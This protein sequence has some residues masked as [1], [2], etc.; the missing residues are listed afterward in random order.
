MNVCKCIDDLTSSVMIK[1][2]NKI[3][4][5]LKPMHSQMERKTESSFVFY[6]FWNTLSSNNFR[7]SCTMYSY[8][9]SIQ[10]Y[11]FPYSTIGM[12]TILQLSKAPQNNMS[13]LVNFL[14]MNLKNFFSSL[15]IFSERINFLENLLL[16]LFGSHLEEALNWEVQILLVNTCSFGLSPVPLIIFIIY[17]W[18]FFLQFFLNKPEQNAGG[19]AVSAATIKTWDSKMYIFIQVTHYFFLQIVFM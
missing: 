1:L 15:K 13:T 6:K 8:A 11:F 4:D 3:Q 10:Q 14:F 17:H 2:L 18:K 7:I 5:Q 16:E 19:E 9:A 12:T